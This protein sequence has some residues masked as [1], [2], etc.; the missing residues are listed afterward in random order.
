MFVI[1]NGVVR[2]LLREEMR[3]KSPQG[4]HIC[5]SILWPSKQQKKA[6]LG[7]NLMDLSSPEKSMHSYLTP[8]FTL[9]VSYPPTSISSMP[10]PVVVLHAVCKKHWKLIRIQC[11]MTFFPKVL[12]Q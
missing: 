6:L 7:G 2:Y 4:R 3:K 10:I 1:N 5:S 11:A 8:L 9:L 12:L